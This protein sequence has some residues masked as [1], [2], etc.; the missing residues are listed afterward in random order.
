[1]SNQHDRI[2][3]YFVD[4]ELRHLRYANPGEDFRKNTLVGE[5]FMLVVI[6]LDSEFKL[7]EVQFHPSNGK[8]LLPGLTHIGVDMCA[9]GIG[10]TAVA[11]YYN[12]PIR[13]HGLKI[14]RN[15]NDPRPVLTVPSDHQQAAA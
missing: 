8:G 7:K 15:S 4:G 13:R 11:V 6:S 12:D 5:E 14:D 3:L 9:I 1:M 10:D 2:G